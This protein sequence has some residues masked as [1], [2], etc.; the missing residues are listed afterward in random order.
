MSIHK[1]TGADDASASIVMSVEPWLSASIYESI[2]AIGTPI[3]FTRSFPAKAS[4]RANVPERI[5][6]FNMLTLSFCATNNN[7]VMVIH[8]PPS[9]NQ[10]W[11]VMYW[12]PSGVINPELFNP[13]IRAKYIIPTT[14]MP[15]HAA[16]HFLIAL[17][18]RKVNRMREKYIIIDPTAN[19]STTDINIPDIITSALPL[20]INEPI[21]LTVSALSFHTLNIA[22]ATA[23][24]S[25]S[26][27][28][29]TVVDVGSPSVL[30]V[31]SSITSL[32]IIP[33]KR[34]MTSLNVNISG[35]KTPFLA[36]SIIPLDV[37]TPINM[38][39]DATTRIVFTPATFEPSAELRKFT[40]SFET[41]TIRSMTANIT[42]IMMITVNNGLIFYVLIICVA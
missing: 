16:P 11:S 17:L 2:P 22:T 3:K 37:I 30:N 15:H 7:A 18:Y 8:N 36:T 21:S 10:I 39:S 13:L 28:S 26:N 35:W 4:A 40:A 24:P 1:C 32:I 41:P 29:E 42:N 9:I 19:D 14:E 12:Y 31:F 23:A 20:L 38:P 25:N 34:N 5:V 33:T 6:N 27:M